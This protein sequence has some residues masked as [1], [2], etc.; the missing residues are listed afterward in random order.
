[1]K[2]ACGCECVIS[3]WCLTES[4]LLSKSPRSFLTA[5]Y[6][7]S[8]PAFTEKSDL[9]KITGNQMMKK[10]D[11]SRKWCSPPQLSNWLLVAD[12]VSEP[13]QS[14]FVPFVISS[15]GRVD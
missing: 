5:L 4:A 15:P 6:S 13:K 7:P 3:Q 12:V 1:M 10:G 8:T 2:S 11:A 9:T 14:A